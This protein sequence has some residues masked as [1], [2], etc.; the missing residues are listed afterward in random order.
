MADA[1]V[2]L[3]SVFQDQRRAFRQHPYPD[4]SE[5]QS[6]LQ[7]LIGLLT[8]NVGAFVESINA[9]FGH[10]CG[11][12]TRLLEIVPSIRSAKYAK[13]NVAKWMKPE[14]KSVAA[15]F[16]FGR[17][18]VIRQPLGVVGIIVPWNFPLL[19]AVGPLVAALAAGNRVMFKISE[20]SPAFGQSFAKLISRNFA[21]DQIAV[22]C[23]GLEV[24]RAFAAMPFDHLLFT[25]STAV[26]R[27]V[28]KAAA[29]NLTPVTLELGGKSPAIVGPDFSVEL[30][31]RRIMWGKCLNAGQSCI[32]PDYVLVPAGKELAFAEAAKSAVRRFFPAGAGGCDYSAIV[33]DRHYQRLLA[34]LADALE[35]GAQCTLLMEGQSETSRKM[36]PMLLQAVRDDMAVMQDE[37]FGPLLPLIPYQSVDDALRFVSDRPRPLAFYYFDRDRRR[38]KGVL[39]RTISGGVTVNDT[40]LHIAQEHLPFGGIGPSG[41]GHYH[42]EDGFLTFSKRKGVFLQSRCTAVGLLDPPYGTRTERIIKWMQ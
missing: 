10:R 26:G 13:A 7:T 12:E 30:A 5:R 42:G 17:A 22:V 1:L 40:M 37:I 38:I 41:M 29:E 19:L 25:G 35:K 23:G 31:A 20:Y 34:Y 21:R 36:P 32:A 33:N 8:E 11:Q 27:E 6:H 18:R 2:D 24:A 28:M 4:A 3:D 39:Q 15:W 14:R 16:R 9:D